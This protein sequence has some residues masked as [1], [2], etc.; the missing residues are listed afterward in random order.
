MDNHRHATQHGVCLALAE[1]DAVHCYDCDRTLA[2][3]E[4]P[5]AVRMIMSSVRQLQLNPP[6]FDDESAADDGDDGD[7]QGSSSSSGNPSPEPLIRRSSRRT[8]V[9]RAKTASAKA[10]HSR[11]TL[12]KF[13]DRWR[14][15]AEAAR[16]ARKENKN[17]AVARVGDDN[18]E[19]ADD[20]DDDDETTES[21]E[22]ASRAKLPKPGKM[23]LL[24]TRST[25]KTILRDDLA[26]FS[27]VRS[28]ATRS[29]T[30]LPFGEVGLR[31]LGN[32]CYLSSV[33]QCL[34]HTLA[35]RDFFT[36]ELDASLL[37]MDPKKLE[38][39]LFLCGE[40]HILLRALWSAKWVTL[41]PHTLLESVWK[42]LPK[43]R[44]YLQQD[45][46]EFLLDVMNVCER[47]LADAGSRCSS[48]HMHCAAVGGAP[49]STNKRAA[50]GS[51]T[52]K[53]AA[54]AAAAAASSL[55]A[56]SHLAC[57]FRG[58]LR[59]DVVCGGCKRVSSTEEPFWQL[60]LD[61]PREPES[62]AN[63]ARRAVSPRRAPEPARSGVSCTLRDCFEALSVAETLSQYACD[64]CSVRQTASKSLH[65]VAMPLVLVVA[66]KRFRWDGSGSKVDVSVSFDLDDVEFNGVTFELTG[67][68]VHHGRS[69]RAG[70]YTAYVRLAADWMHCNDGRLRHVSDEVVLQQ[71]T[72]AYMFF[73][74]R[75]A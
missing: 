66:L 45:A 38:K 22:P 30:G 13:F 2:P 49:P 46:Q 51:S 55:P 35:V 4:L 60:T 26:S 75:K 29:A 43:Y 63:A 24:L 10:V 20:D 53:P 40:L 9:A 65:V 59:S 23:S 71:A 58:K 36:V 31:N 19:D 41:S 8:A 68:V 21:I 12:V 62:A 33:V 54:A 7:V 72:S 74:Q 32:T 44:H 56:Q 42:F 34:S 16:R 52:R 70:H 39:P 3:A 28:N 48:A 73:F 25:I 5:D 14:L 11:R 64:R 37:R 18:D 50:A 17:S 57:L 67:I 47:E 1:A 15:A 6:S 69:L 61:L 27:R